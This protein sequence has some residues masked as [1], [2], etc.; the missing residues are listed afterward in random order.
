MVELPVGP[1][2]TIGISGPLDVLTWL[3]A[4]VGVLSTPSL[5]MAG[6]RAYLDWRKL[7]GHE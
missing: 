3:L 2:T 5:Q 7:F 1:Q 4:L 6:Q